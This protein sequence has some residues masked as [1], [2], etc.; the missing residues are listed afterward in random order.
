MAHTLILDVGKTNAKIHVLNAQGAWEYSTQCAN[1]VVSDGAY[2]HFRAESLWLWFA[3]SV[4]TIEFELKREIESI[5]VTT[6][7]AT[8]AL[9]NHLALGSEALVLP[10]MDYEF[11]GVEALSKEYRTQCSSFSQS[12]SPALPAGL[13]L[14]LQLF[15]MQ[16]QFPETF[17]RASHILM[18]PQYW[19]WR[20]SG[21]L[22]TEVSSLGCHTDLWNSRQQCYS[23]LVHNCGWRGMFP[24]LR[25]AWEVLGPLLPS[26]ATKLGL[27]AQCKVH[28]GVHD[29]NASYL[30]YLARSGS[31][32]VFSTGTWTIAMTSACE[33]RHLHSERDMLANTAVNGET[34][35]CSRFMGGREYDIICARTG[36]NVE[37]I[38]SEA[39]LL[40]V[41]NEQCF[42]LPNFCPGSGPYPAAEAQFVG[43]I[44]RVNGAAMATLYCALMMDIQADL[45]HAQGDIFI[46]GAFLKNPW[47]CRIFAALRSDQRVYL[48]ADETGTVQGCAQ[49][50]AWPAQPSAPKLERCEKAVLSGLHAYRQRWR[51]F[52]QSG[53]APH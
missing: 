27:S 39:D 24:P 33:L 25:S 47:L 32:C 3:N 46:E 1:Q 11:T 44:N 6:H 4:K 17:R 8:A 18:Y 35:A 22:S 28:V 19:A 40:A 51:Q 16:R 36:A 9:V 42:A 43:E 38:I 52:Q 45:L 5:C 12:F 10:I 34:V 15:W 49:L 37:A 30:R 41:L 7:G 2:P 29:S 21:E 53:E 48:S 26:L 23:A 13:N 20:L 31:F 14:G 50:A